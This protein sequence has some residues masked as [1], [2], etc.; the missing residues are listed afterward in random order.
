MTDQQ[1]NNGQGFG[2]AGLVLGIIA[3]V[4]SFIPC[5]GMWAIFPGAIAIVLSAIGMSQAAKANASRGLLIAALV[6]S[7]IGT[8][9]AGWQFI[10][11]RSAADKI[12]QN[13]EGWSDE[14]KNAIDDL[15]EDGTL[16]GL[17][18]ALN[19]LEEAVEDIESEVDEAMD[20]AQ[21]DIEAELD[22]LESEVEEQ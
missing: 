18:D 3:L 19:D 6:V 22:S 10:I 17:E 14:L 4:I 21:R 8:A 13:V 11:L 12:E 1:S 7:I 15:E 2:I 9:I 20:E 16:E 5:L